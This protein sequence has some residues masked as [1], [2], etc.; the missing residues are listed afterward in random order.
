MIA[1]NAYKDNETKFDKNGHII[2]SDDDKK[3]FEEEARAHGELDIQ[4]QR[5]EIQKSKTNLCC[6]SRHF[7]NSK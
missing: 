7:P 5:L 4:K 3:I 1:E 6:H 2:I